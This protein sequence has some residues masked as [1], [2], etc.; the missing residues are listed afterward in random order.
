M[1]INEFQEDFMQ[2][3]KS[4]AAIAGE[5]S[6]AAFV[7]LAVKYLIDA[8]VLSDFT[9]AFYNGI[10]KNGRKLR[11]DGYV[12]D[13]FDDTFNLIIAN[14]IG[15][16]E[17]EII[18]RTIAATFFDR[19]F[20]FAE[21]ALEGKLDRAVE[22]S[23]PVADLIV[24]LKQYKERIRKFRLILL[25][26]GFMSN[27]I[28]EIESRIYYNIPVECQIWD[29]D[30]IFRVSAS[31][32]GRQTIEIDFKERCGKGLP[33]LEASSANSGEVKSYLC[34][35]PGAVLADIYDKFGSQLLEGNVRSF[36]STKVAVNKKIRETILTVPQNFF[37]YNN[38][39]SA[40]AMDLIVEKEGD[41]KYITYAKDFQI[42]NG[43]QTTASLS[44]ARYKDKADLSAIYV[45]MKLTEVDSNTEKASELIRNISKSS[46]SQN[47]VSDADFFATHPFHI[48]MEK[49]SRKLFAPATGGAQYET[50]WFYERARGQYL[51]EQMHLSKAQ[52]DKFTTQQPKRQVITKTDFAKFR[53][54]WDRLPHIVSKGAQTNFLKFAE[55]ADSNWSKNDT[56]FNEKYFKDT[57]ALAILFKHTEYIV[58][59]QPWFAQGYRANIVTYSIALL[60]ELI[61]KQFQ[62][63][64]LDLQLIWN[65]QQVPSVIT[66]ELIKITKF[67]FEKITA[68]DR[69]TIN[70]TQ[71]CKREACWERVK[72]CDI[73]LSRE[74]EKVLLNRD[75]TRAAERDAKKEQ[76]LITDIEAQKQVVEYGAKLWRDIYEFIMSK[77]IS[78]T[79]D[80]VEAMVCASKIPA[81]IPNGYQ[82]AQLLNLLQEAISNGFKK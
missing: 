51:Q 57:I 42:I 78:I 5:G 1:D 77:R 20:Y 75:E 9:P 74:V 64:D 70:V 63:K 13:E 81:R 11:V 55:I 76:K 34:I 37:A 52:K 38:G 45:Q 65:R 2:E 33:C 58:S 3:V 80:Q 67:V 41:G 48:R 39:V 12:Y 31:S 60:H 6:C 27:R 19:L 35:I 28:S 22:E 26:N 18:T 68:P 25:T 44:N 40:T 17:Q 61:I 16:N 82:S 29:V 66:N 49:F 71:W 21:E 4:T 50:K 53:N 32:Q 23:T 47:K 54:T 8:E 36:L 24:N 56:Q 62:D 69:D 73:V 10:G 15:A 43:G 59:H 30:R 46:N 72:K 79:P 7:N 14:Y